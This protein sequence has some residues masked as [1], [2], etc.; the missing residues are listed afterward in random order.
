MGNDA[1]PL[2][3]TGSATNTLGAVY[4]YGIC[5]NTTLVGA[6]RINEGATKVIGTMGGVT[7]VGTYH[8]APNGVRYN[9]LR[10]VLTAADDVT[11]FTRAA[12]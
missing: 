3:L 11:V 9:D 8:L 6:V 10:I 2:K 5:I 1:N 4:L 12:S 7:P